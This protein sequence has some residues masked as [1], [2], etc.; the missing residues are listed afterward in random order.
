MAN[1]T[2]GIVP[3]IIQL[4]IPGHNNM[5][6]LVSMAI[7]SGQSACPIGTAQYLHSKKWLIIRKDNSVMHGMENIFSGLVN[8]DSFAPIAIV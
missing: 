5:R 8:V 6:W 2:I 4:L 3:T 1:D 7:I